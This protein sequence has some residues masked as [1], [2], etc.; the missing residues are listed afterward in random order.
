MGDV[1]TFVIAFFQKCVNPLRDASVRLKAQYPNMFLGLC[2]VC[3]FVLP[4]A[5]FILVVNQLNSIALTITRY[6]FDA[7]L[8]NAFLAKVIF[9]HACGWMLF[10]SQAT[11]VLLILSATFRIVLQKR[12]EH[13]YLPLTKPRQSSP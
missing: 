6:G 12:P 7:S 3:V 10:A 4:T 13:G 5:I 1:F 8:V 2:G 11:G 9:S